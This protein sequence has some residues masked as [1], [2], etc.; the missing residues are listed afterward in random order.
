MLYIISTQYILDFLDF[1]E[2]KNKN[3]KKYPCLIFHNKSEL[4]NIS[5]L[6]NKRY[7]LLQHDTLTKYCKSLIDIYINYFIKPMIIYDTNFEMQNIIY[8]ILKILKYFYFICGETEQKN[9]LMKYISEV[10]NTLS[11]FR[12]QSEYQLSSDSREF[13]YYLLLHENNFDSLSNSMTM[14]PMNEYDVYSTKFNMATDMMKKVLYVKKNIEQGKKFEIVESVNKKNS[15]IY[16]ERN[17]FD[18][19]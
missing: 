19:L 12:K 5:E 1:Q 13:G 16:L 10:L 3:T 7:K 14:S 15:I 9:I 18:Y 6:N 17:F 11:Q 8:E 4:F 2:S